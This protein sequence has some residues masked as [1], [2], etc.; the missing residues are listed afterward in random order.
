[1]EELLKK[2]L[3]V[4]GAKELVP[5]LKQEYESLLGKISEKNQEAQG[6]RE[7]EE[8]LKETLNAIMGKLNA[9]D[10]KEALGTVDET[11]LALNKYKSDYDS[12]AKVVEELKESNESERKKVETANKRDVL[13]KTI[14]ES[15][16]HPD[17]RDEALKLLESDFKNSEGDWVTDD[18]KRLEEYV[19]E[20]FKTR[21]NWLEN[22]TT[23]GAGSL[24]AADGK[25]NITDK[26]KTM[27]EKREATGEL[28]DGLFN[29]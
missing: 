17:M 2:L 3:E 25:L 22:K 18:G 6:R 13:R 19:P 27:A 15:G 12:L 4:D 10:P 29:K 24:R 1:M 23:G 21:P 28:V 26:P 9:K 7:S 14:S 16:V 8:G 20:Y 11:A 5:T